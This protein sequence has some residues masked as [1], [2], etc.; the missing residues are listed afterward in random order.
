M[1]TNILEQSRHWVII[2]YDLNTTLN[3]LL[4]ED[5]TAIKV[6]CLASNTYGSDKASTLIKLCGNTLIV[7]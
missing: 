7:R 4:Q 5:T 3:T 2:L 1:E 6:I